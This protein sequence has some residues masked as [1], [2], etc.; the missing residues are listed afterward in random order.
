MIPH[1]SKKFRAIRD[2]SFGVKLSSGERVSSV[3]ETTTLQA[4]TG[5]IDQLGHSLSQLIHA[6]TE[7]S[8]EGK[9]FSAKYNIKDGFWRLD[10]KQGEEWNFAYVRPREPGEQVLLV[11]P[12]SLQM[13]WVESPPYFCTASETARDVGAKYIE[14]PVATLPKHKFIKHA[15]TS[16]D[17]QTLPETANNDTLRYLWTCM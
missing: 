11:V 15:M 6:S 7:A 5:A 1:K 17:V 3:N 13:G 8:E 4:P 12:T 2:L 10:C 14:R 9:V 16:N